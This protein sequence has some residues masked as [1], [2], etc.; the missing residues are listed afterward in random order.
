MQS[1]DDLKD[2]GECVWIACEHL[3]MYKRLEHLQII[4]C[5]CVVW[6][7]GTNVS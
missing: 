4:V 3:L 2:T 1:K 7:A 6:E 5:G